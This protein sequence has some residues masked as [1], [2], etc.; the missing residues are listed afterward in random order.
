VHPRRRGP[1]YICR[2]SLEPWRGRAVFVDRHFLFPAH[3]ARLR[4]LDL[5]AGEVVIRVE[6]LGKKYI[7]GH[8]SER[9]RYTALRDVAAR[10]ARNVGNGRS[11]RARGAAP[12]CAGRRPRS[13][14]R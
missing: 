1:R 7:I 13:S 8:E 3:R 9:E 5:M 2:V 4:G 10:A 11:T 6:G 12:S 14:G